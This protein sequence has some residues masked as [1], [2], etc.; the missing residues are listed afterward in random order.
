MLDHLPTVSIVTP[1]FNQAQFLE[2]TI[3]SVRAQDYARVEYIIIDGASSDGSIDI[4]R[5][6]EDHLA[7]WTSERDNGQT[8]AI[9]KGFERSTGQ[10]LAWLNSDDLLAP[11]AVRIAVDALRRAPDIGGVYGDRLHI[12][13]RSNVIGINRMPAFYPAMFK[14]NITLPQETVFFRRSVYEA[15]GGL[16]ATLRFSLDFDLWV[17]MSAAAGFRHIPAFLGSF[18]E[19]VTSKSIAFHTHGNRDGD[20]YVEEHGRVFRGHFG[21]ALPTPAMTKWYRIRHKARLA[22][23]QASESYRN[24]VARIKTLVEQPE[25][26]VPAWVS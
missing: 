3:Q 5:K 23:E 16:D 22:M 1:S 18:R 4:I 15:V 24:E 7:S 10:I 2:A 12:D 6:H 14:R 17:R 8:S 11:S 13:A 20:R 25:P 19:H 9:I 26:P 21:R